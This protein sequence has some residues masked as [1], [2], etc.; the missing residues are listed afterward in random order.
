MAVERASG[1]PT[2][3]NG[4]STS[5][6]WLPTEFLEPGGVYHPCNTQADRGNWA[7]YERT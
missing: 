3:W 7:L 2:E 1:I 6:A 4:K 5:L